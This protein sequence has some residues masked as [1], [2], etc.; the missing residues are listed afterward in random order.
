MY[1]RYG[2]PLTKEQEEE[3]LQYLKK[4]R[5]D[6]FQQATSEREKDP[7]R[8][9]RT[10]RSMWYFI[11]GL[12]SLPEPVR[13]A[14]EARHMLRIQMWRL[15]KELKDTQSPGRKKELT[16]QIHELA[17][18]HFDADQIIRQHRLSQLEGY[19]ERL[20]RELKER[21]QDRQAVVRETVERMISSAERYRQRSERGPRSRPSSRPSTGASS[22][23]KPP[24]K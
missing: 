20:K 18:K 23:H 10:I 11:S 17:D 9:Q 15:A 7:R 16:K 24:A 3:V 12:K 2:K 14:E 5:P 19:I 13:D 22:H 6:L 8:Y 4:K 1:R 21:A